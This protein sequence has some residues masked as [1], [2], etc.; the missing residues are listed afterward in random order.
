[1]EFKVGD[2]IKALDEEYIYKIE[3][4]G[5]LSFGE[6]YMGKSISQGHGRAFDVNAKHYRRA[7]EEEINE[8]LSNAPKYFPFW[9]A[10][11]RNNLISN[12]QIFA[13]TLEKAKE[14]FNEKLIRMNNVGEY[15]MS[16]TPLDFINDKTI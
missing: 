6:T 12:G 1:M 13:L 15:F 14:I 7:T 11:K 10:D 16:E 4:V 9:V 3:K 5:R 8:E 2:F